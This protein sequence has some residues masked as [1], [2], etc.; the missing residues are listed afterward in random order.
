MG[1]NYDGKFLWNQIVSVAIIKKWKS[2]KD[3]WSGLVC[4]EYICDVKGG[5]V[6]VGNKLQLVMT[7]V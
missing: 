5:G 6:L 4:G 1:M 3:G 7:E 2:W